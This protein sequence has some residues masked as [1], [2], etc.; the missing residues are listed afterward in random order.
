MSV[1]GYTF[2]ED[3]TTEQAWVEGP[4]LRDIAVLREQAEVPLP[5]EGQ[6]RLLH[7]E[8]A[9]KQARLDG[10]E[11][12]I[13]EGILLSER[14]DPS[15]QDWVIQ[16]TARRNQQ[17]IAKV[18]DSP[19]LTTVTKAL[20]AVERAKER[21]KPTAIRVRDRAQTWWASR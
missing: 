16:H 10:G 19:V 3:I 8:T 4:P 13:F 14:N 7:D 2:R 9:R 18:I 5:P 11:V 12:S 15:V 1:L 21:A 6:E 20:L 17:R